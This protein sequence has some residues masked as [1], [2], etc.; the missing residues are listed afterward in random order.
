M[1]AV[2]KCGEA[3]HPGAVRTKLL[4]HLVVRLICPCYGAQC[5]Y[6]AIPRIDGDVGYRQRDLLIVSEFAARFLVDGIRDA[7][8]VNGEHALGTSVAPATA[9]LQS[10]SGGNR[11]QLDTGV[12][13]Q[14]V[15][16]RR[17]VGLDGVGRDVEGLG[18]RLVGAPLGHQR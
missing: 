6:E 10:L 9:L 16:Q 13:L 3:N 12:G 18:D 11:G 14:L 8:A 15:Q 2:R 1:E 17:N 5:V 7:A 4:V